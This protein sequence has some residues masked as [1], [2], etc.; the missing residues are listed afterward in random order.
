MIND[1]KKYSILIV[2]DDTFLGE[3]YQRTLNTAGYKTTLA[4]DGEAGL[5]LAQAK[6]DLILLD[7]MMPKL[8][9]IDV[10][11]KLRQDT[12]TKDITIVMLT[13]FGQDDVIKQAYEL[14]ANG[15]LLKIQYTPYEIIEQ[16]KNFLENPNFQKELN[17]SND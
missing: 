9:G 5:N 11:K 2:E 3:L 16:I 14:G 1:N 13:N 10:L 8:N 15:Y 6:P 4:A 17:K 7:I 12:K